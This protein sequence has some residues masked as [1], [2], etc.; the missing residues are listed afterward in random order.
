MSTT[1]KKSNGTKKRVSNN[2][3]NASK[4]GNVVLIA[5][6]AA[7]I[8]FGAAHLGGTKSGKIVEN[9]IEPTETV[10][11]IDG[12]DGVPYEEEEQIIN[13]VVPAEYV[14]EAPVEEASVPEDYYNYVNDEIYNKLVTAQN[15]Y[16]E[17]FNR[18][19]VSDQL[20]LKNIENTNEV[21]QYVSD[22]MRYDF[23][24]ICSY[25]NAYNSRDFNV[26]YSTAK[27]LSDGYIT[28][29]SR[30]YLYSILVTPVLSSEFRSDFYQNDNDGSIILN[31][32]N[33]IHLIGE[34]DELIRMNN[35]DTS[36]VFDYYTKLPSILTSDYRVIHDP[37]QDANT[38][39]VLEASKVNQVN[40]EFVT[41]LRSD[42]A[43]EYDVSEEE[44]KILWDENESC[45]YYANADYDYIAYLDYDS[46][47]RFN[48]Y[49]EIEGA[50]SDESGDAYVLDAAIDSL[51]NEYSYVK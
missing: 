42:A 14:E 9:D 43:E 12:V 1:N 38:C 41:E 17:F 40:R 48:T 20:V 18:G 21:Y 6:L 10:Q 22:Q 34:N 49:W 27:E 13:E 3:N 30:E 50:L 37:N 23:E 26:C 36:T 16:E 24:L 2:K 31:N 7:A 44:L 39:F 15:N 11:A 51:E 45:W 5:I 33:R 29:L 35:Y 8:G 28:G 19:L 25:V 4:T 47:N 32:G 46:N